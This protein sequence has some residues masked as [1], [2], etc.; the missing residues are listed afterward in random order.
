MSSLFEKRFKK[1]FD[2]NTFNKEI[3]LQQISSNY[4]FSPRIIE[5]GETDEYAFIRMEKL[6]GYDLAWVF[7]DNESDIPEEIWDKMREIIRILYE[8]ENIVYV[9]ITPYNFVE[10]KGEIYIIDFGDAYIY[11]EKDG[12]TKYTCSC[13]KR[14]D[15]IND[16][17]LEFLDGMNKWNSDFR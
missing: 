9:D 3:V 11:T 12:T 13:H 4:G 6:E 2:S 14:N 1:P 10:V 16:Y 7:G 17:F 8:E 5:W 15:C